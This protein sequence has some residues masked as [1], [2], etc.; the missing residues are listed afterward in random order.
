MNILLCER[1]NEANQYVEEL[2]KAYQ[3]RGHKV[4]FD[5]QNFL[6]SDFLPD[7][8]HI[9]W[10][11]A[12]Y[13][14]RHKLHANDEILDLF[15]RRFVY[16]SQNKVPIAYTA[17]NILPHQN[18]VSFD[19]AVYKTILSYADIVVHHG[20]S[21]IAILKNYFPECKKAFHVICPHGPYPYTAMDS[22]KARALYSLPESKYVFL[23]FG[24]QRQNKGP[25]FIRKVFLKW[26]NP[27]TFLFVIGP[28]IYGI[29]G[30]S[31]YPK[32]KA[33]FSA[34]LDSFYVKLTAAL[35][36]EIRIVPRQVSHSEIP[37]ILASSDVVFLG[38]QQGLN[39]GILALAA[40]YGKPVVFPDI[41]NFKEQLLGWP[42]CESYKVGDIN[43]ALRALTK[44]K[45]KIKKYSSENIVFN[46]KT[47]LKNNSW[48]IHVEQIENTIEKIKK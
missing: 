41:G 45:K 39:S 44:M 42:W 8:V 12:I 33:I 47:W 27:D 48:D 35:S 15:R 32:L 24:R 38:H 7:L 36:K 20:E 22:K 21:S 29:K 3:G 19:R 2:A 10:P 17:H 11:E 31:F 13:H 14:W 6:Y 46:N 18:A 23:N 26:N 16:Y 34:V 4:I 5:V 37:I 1:I 28:R 40:S 9:Q 43:S 30:K 25:D